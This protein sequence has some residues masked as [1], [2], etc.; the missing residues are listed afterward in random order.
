M[1]VIAYIWGTNVEGLLE[2]LAQHP[3]VDRVTWKTSKVGAPKKLQ[4]A[5]LESARAMY[6]DPGFSIAEIAGNFEVS[7]ATL[8]RAMIAPRKKAI[9]LHK[10]GEWT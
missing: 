4:G 8:R 7:E 1:V 10:K 5:R 2:G 9:A 6:V 3:E